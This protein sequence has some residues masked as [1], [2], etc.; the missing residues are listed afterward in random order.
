M[1]FCSAFSIVFIAPMLIPASLSRYVADVNQLCWFELNA[2]SRL[3]TMVLPI[4]SL[5]LFF[6]KIRWNQYFIIF[7]KM[8]IDRG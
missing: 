2:T 8:L 5:P 3:S 7:S 6:K 1:R 4:R